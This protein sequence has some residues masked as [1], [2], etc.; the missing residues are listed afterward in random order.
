MFQTL[1][2][3]NLWGHLKGIAF[4]KSA[5]M[6]DRLLQQYGICLKF[7]STIGILGSIGLCYA[8]KVTESI[9]NNI[10]IHVVNLKMLFCSFVNKCAP[11]VNCSLSHLIS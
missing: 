8:F 10:C 6:Q 2:P 3:A 5:A 11:V 9:C 7:F 1:T 4:L